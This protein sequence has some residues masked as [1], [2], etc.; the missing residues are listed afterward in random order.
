MGNQS[1]IAYPPKNVRCDQQF[2]E[3]EYLKKAI[4]PVVYKHSI[5]DVSE[6]DTRTMHPARKKATL[7]N[8]GNYYLFRH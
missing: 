7:N 8:N 5:R 3:F 1:G 4:D 2:K 6:L